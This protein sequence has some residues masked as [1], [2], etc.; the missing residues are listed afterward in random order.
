MW[1]VQKEKIKYLTIFTLAGSEKW[2]IIKL[3]RSQSYICSSI[4][5]PARPLIYLSI[6]QQSLTKFITLH[7]LNYYLSSSV[8]DVRESTRKTKDNSYLK[9]YRMLGVKVPRRWCYWDKQLLGSLCNVILR[10]LYAGP[11]DPSS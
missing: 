1:S 7:L 4:H 3:I 9:I 10:E 6:Y 2:G 11:H 5:P 8:V